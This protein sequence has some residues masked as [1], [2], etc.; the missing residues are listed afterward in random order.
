MVM[1][2]CL[3]VLR[4]ANVEALVLRALIRYHPDGLSRIVNVESF[5]LCRG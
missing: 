1:Y 2:A 5:S 3:L 4:I